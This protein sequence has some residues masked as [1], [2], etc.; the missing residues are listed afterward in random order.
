MVNASDASTDDGQIRVDDGDIAFRITH[1]EDGVN[2]AFGAIELQIGE[3]TD[4][5]SSDGSGT[6]DVVQ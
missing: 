5:G 3:A 2:Y 6:G 4:N 1:S